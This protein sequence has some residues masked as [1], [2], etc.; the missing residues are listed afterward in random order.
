MTCIMTFLK[1]VL[2][3]WTDL[4]GAS[5]PLSCGVGRMDRGMPD[6]LQA[7]GGQYVYL[8]GK[9]RLEAGKL[10]LDKDDQCWP[11]LVFKSEA[12]EAT[13]LQDLLTHGSSV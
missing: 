3:M 10:H 13:Q 2:V 6:G 1:V 11:V 7:I 12:P 9:H 4:H 5:G 8:D